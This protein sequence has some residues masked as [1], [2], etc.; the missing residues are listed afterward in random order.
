MTTNKTFE[1]LTESEIGYVLSLN[2]IDAKGYLLQT[3]GQTCFE[4]F[5][6]R[7]ALQDVENLTP[8]K[9]INQ[10]ERIQYLHRQ[11]QNADPSTWV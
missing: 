4:G 10:N 7:L 6:Q 3:H 1:D 11:D 9:I 5:L 8:L 2:C